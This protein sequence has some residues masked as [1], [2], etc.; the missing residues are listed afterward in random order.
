MKYVFGT[1]VVLVG[2]FIP[3]RAFAWSESPSVEKLDDETF[4]EMTY[5]QCAFRYTASKLTESE[6]DCLC[7]QLANHALMHR[8]NAS[9]V[10]PLPDDMEAACL[11]K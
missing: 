9:A 4:Y 2:L 1:I 11:S 5:T 10:P 6:V 8:E 3:V 7:N